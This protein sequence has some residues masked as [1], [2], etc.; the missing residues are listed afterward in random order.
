MGNAGRIR[1]IL[2]EKAKELLLE[3][4]R[5]I[6]EASELSEFSDYNYFITFFTKSTWI[7]PRKWRKKKAEKN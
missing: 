7:S 5:S 2:F 4:G 1:Y 3:Q 6:S